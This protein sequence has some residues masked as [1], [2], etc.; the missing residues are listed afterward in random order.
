[1]FDEEVKIIS[2]IK[3]CKTVE[4]VNSCADWLI[5]IKGTMYKHTKSY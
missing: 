5:R 1:M 3:S 2:T 4:H